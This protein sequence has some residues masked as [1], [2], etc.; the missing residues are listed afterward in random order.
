MTYNMNT[1]FQN[2]CRC[3]WEEN[4][5]ELENLL[6]DS[7]NVI[8]SDEECYEMID[9]FS[10]EIRKTVQGCVNICGT[11]GSRI[12]KPNISSIASLYLAVIGEVPVVKSGSKSN[13][14]LFGSSDF[15]NRLG[16]LGYLDKGLFL[17]KYNWGYCDYLE[18]SPWKRYKPILKSND[19]FADFFKRH[20]VFDYTASRF[21]LGISNPEYHNAIPQHIR[22]HCPQQ[23]DTFYTVT[24]VGVL[25]EIAP[26]RVF[27]N[28]EY[29]FETKAIPFNEMKSAEE[30][31]QINDSLLRGNCRDAF[32]KQTLLQT[33]ALSAA[34]LCSN[35]NRF[36]NYYADAERLYNSGEISRILLEM[37]KDQKTIADAFLS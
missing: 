23:L 3:I 27:L 7:R 29:L 8:F 37:K 18:L 16:I 1:F 30:I 12:A 9:S 15:F 4:Q 28:G 13:T 17:K 32:W 31:M 19:C 33:V 11:G 20:I 6:F 36:D 35:L 25:D 14:G 21:L 5:S 26:G 24:Q 10:A 22:H 2:I 34:I